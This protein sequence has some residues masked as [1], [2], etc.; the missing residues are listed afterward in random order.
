MGG[1]IHFVEMVRTPVGAVVALVV[2]VMFVFYIKWL[3]SEPDD[4]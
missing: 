1:M 4:E 2:V 3:L